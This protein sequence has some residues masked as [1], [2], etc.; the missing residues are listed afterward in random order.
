MAKKEDRRIKKSKKSIKK[1]F[2]DLIHEKGFGAISVHDIAERADIN[3][4]TFYLHYQDKFDLFE[5]YVDEL[6]NELIKTIEISNEEKEK[7]KDGIRDCE[8]YVQ[9]FKHFQEHSYFYEAMFSYKG[10]TYFYIRFI[11]VFKRHFCQE[12]KEL[13]V[14]EEQLK[15]DKDFLIHSMIYAHFG[16]I[17]YWLANGMSDSPETMGA[18]LNTLLHSISR[19]NHD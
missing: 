8:P 9:F 14:N 17:N 1:S 2:I 13:K 19:L 16:S 15:V 10:D 5:K 18:Q 4:G 6:L 3:R 12:F 7:V 11:D